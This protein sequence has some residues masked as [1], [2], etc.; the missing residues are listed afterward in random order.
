[1]FREFFLCAS[2]DAVCKV[3]CR[4][5]KKCGRSSE[6]TVLRF[7]RFCEKKNY[8]RKWAWPM[9]KDATD[10]SESVDIKVLTVGGLCGRYSPKCVFRTLH[11]PIRRYIIS[12]FLANPSG[13][14]FQ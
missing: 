13:E 9:P 12:S 5:V 3:W 14:I 8:G 7:S 11:W 6:N 10:S 1:M 4:L 2:E